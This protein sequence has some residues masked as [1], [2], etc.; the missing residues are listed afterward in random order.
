MTK[1]KKEVEKLTCIDCEKLKDRTKWFYNTKNKLY[2]K[3][4]KIPICKACLKEKIDYDDIETIYDIFK[5]LDIVFHLKYW[6][7]AE[8]GKS[9]TFGRYMSMINTLH[10]LEGKTWSDSIFEFVEE[11]TEEA[12]IVADIYPPSEPEE[13]TYDEKNKEDVLRMVGYDPFEG[14]LESDKRHLY[15]KLVDMLD[16]ST[17]EDGFKLSAIIEIVKGFNQ[18]DKINRSIAIM[19]SDV[20]NLSKSTNAIKQLVATKKQIMDSL[21]ALAK[22]NGISV[23]HNNNKSKGGNTLNGIVKKLNEIGLEAAELN[24]YNIETSEAMKQIADISNRSILDQLMFDENDYT[25]MIAQQ[26]DM[27]TDL[28]AKLMKAEEENRLL[29]IQINE[30]KKLTQS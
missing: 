30:L 8:E 24:L 4:K 15:N 22:D 20:A 13:N 7:I 14:E 5:R 17:L 6:E 9:D 18:V 27:I 1:D 11:E 26:K 19:T 23:N 10:Q 28:D 29:K 12:P 3:T 25:E 16:E 2:D 21:I